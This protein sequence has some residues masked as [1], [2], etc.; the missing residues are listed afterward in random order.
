MLKFKST[1]H[2]QF[3]KEKKWSRGRGRHR[4]TIY[5]QVM[6]LERMFKR[7][8]NGDPTVNALLDEL[9]E[10]A[11]RAVV[12]RK[13]QRIQLIKELNQKISEIVRAIRASRRR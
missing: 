4:I 9:D 8:A 5:R 13:Y 10:I 7:F 6:R 1:Y 11:S 2:M 12:S 3:Q